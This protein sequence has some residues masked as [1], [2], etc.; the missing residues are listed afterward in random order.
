[1]LKNGS[2]LNDRYEIVGVVGSGGMSDVYKAKCHK[3]NRYV[4][5]KVLKK[6]FSDDKNFVAKFRAEAQSAAGLSHPN[7]VNIYD[8]GE[9]NG[10][11]Y[12][13]MEYVEGKTLKQ[14]LKKKKKQVFISEKF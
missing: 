10:Q 5:I 3:L 4:A 6:E 7:I 1:M 2:M 12:I 11:H 8:V 13:V 14:L 9:E